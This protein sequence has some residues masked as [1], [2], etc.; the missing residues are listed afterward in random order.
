M[1]AESLKA[2]FEQHIDQISKNER[3]IAVIQKENELQ[4]RVF[5]KFEETVEKLQDLVEAMN[6]MIT[7]HDEKIRVQERALETMESD[8][9]ELESRLSK[10]LEDTE[11][12]ILDKIAELKLERSVVVDKPNGVMKK[13]DAY[14][15]FILGGIFAVGVAMG[16]TSLVSNIF[17]IFYYLSGIL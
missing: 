5:I 2:L 8:I 9:K 11:N 4:T 10:K 14:K 12:R 3:D 13:L 15:W 1:S 16:K 17:S 6:R 7:I